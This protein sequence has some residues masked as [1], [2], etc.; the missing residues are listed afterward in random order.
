MKKSA[1]KIVLFTLI[2][3]LVA[4]APA[5]AALRAEPVTRSP[6]GQVDR[7]DTDLFTGGV[8]YSYPINIPKGTNDLT[9]EVSLSYNSHGAR[10]L[11]KFTGAGWKLS[12]DFI[13][14]DINFSPTNLSDDKYRLHFQSGVYD[15]VFV[16]ADNRY[17]TKTESYLNIQKLSG[18]QNE[19]GE[20]WQ[21]ITQDG[22]KY[23]FGYQSQ[24]ELMCGGR[25]YI[26]RW[27]IDEVTDT[28]NNHIFYTYFDSLGTTYPLKIEYN[29]DKLRV[30]DFTYVSDPYALGAYTQGCNVSESSQLKEISIKANSSVVRSYA[31]S[32]T[33]AID[34]QQLLSSITEKGTDGSALP[35][36]SFT[37]KPEIRNWNIQNEQWLVQAPLDAHLGMNSVALIDVNGDG[38]SDIV[39]S[40]D[41]AWQVLLNLG[42]SWSTAYQLWGSNIDAYLDWSDVRLVD[43]TGDN[44]PDIVKEDQLTFRV[45]RNT[46][47][48]WTSTAESWTNGFGPQLDDP[49]K[50]AAIVD[51]N[52]DGRAE[53]LKT[54]SSG[55]HSL[56]EVWL[57]AGSG[58]GTSVQTWWNNVPVDASLSQSNV[59]LADVNGDSLPDI[60]KTT[61]NGSIATWL[62]YKNTGT[63][64]STSPETW[65]N[66]ANIDAYLGRDDVVLTDADGDGLTDILKTDDNEHK[67]TWKILR[68][69]GGG[70]SLPWEIW[71]D[72]SANVGLDA[73]SLH[74]R[75]ADV[76]G[77]GLPDIV[78]GTPSCTTCGTQVTWHVYKNLGKAS[79]LLSTVKTAQGATISFEYKAATSFDNTGS[80]DKPD[81]PFNLWLV[82]KKTENN[83]LSNSQQTNDI[84]TYNY[85]DGFYKWQEREFRGFGTIDE[86]VAGGNNKKYVFHQ[87]DGLRG[88][89]LELQV[90]DTQNNPFAET[91]NT[92]TS[93]L[94]N[95]VYTNKL[96][97]EKQYTYDGTA[98]NPKVTQTEYQYDTFGNVT[99]KSERGD[100]AITGDERFTYF[101]YTTNPTLWITNTL[102]HTL[103]RSAT[104]TINVSESWL[105]YDGHAGLDETPTKGE[106]TKEV[107]WLEGGTN[108]VTLYEYNAFGNQTK[109]TDAKNNVTQYTYDATGTHPAT[110]T[111]AKNQTTTTTYNLGTGNLLTI[112]DPK[113]S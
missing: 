112:T 33:T 63:T 56:W 98:A 48:S 9:P 60:V 104:D 12:Q 46:G 37:Y 21:V 99:K 45:W 23:R 62:V 44:L 36:V 2:L 17:H 13:E 87:D 3:F 43:V 53:L 42:N 32:Y 82:E 81:L 22:T 34:E 19:R 75:I 11:S 18:G 20:Y 84:T 65:V 92:W 52:G 113:T 57:N 64:W 88:M 6:L 7:Y 8:V 100:T 30:I 76:T 101:E 29:N 16:P 95:G 106:V 58:W 59:R 1:L 85:K 10:D 93:S 97:Q 109:V 78:R 96:T 94:A 86:N 55:S 67:D 103:L 61:N 89:L 15:L 80:D 110:T 54:Y 71:I 90:R 49:S 50:G 91:E 79:N 77:D 66:N 51:L 24:S 26:S 68:N 47:S 108:P 28:N 38:L 27:F 102:K 25:D 41:S 69:T 107:T 14:R 39:K 35:P 70:W 105:Y 83:G 4:F 74:N 72:P 73:Q 31:L 111:N 40:A 5:S